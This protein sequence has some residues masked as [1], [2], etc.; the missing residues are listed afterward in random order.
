MVD[1]VLEEY[2]NCLPNNKLLAVKCVLYLGKRMLMVHY[3]W[4]GQ[5]RIT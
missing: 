4:S 1:A 2:N 5:L 3:E